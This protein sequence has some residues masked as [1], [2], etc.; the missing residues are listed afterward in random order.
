MEGGYQPK[1]GLECVPLAPGEKLG[2]KDQEP[3]N[4]QGHQEPS[5]NSRTGPF[6]GTIIENSIEIGE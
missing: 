1:C 4:A 2:E 6:H 3:R 5:T